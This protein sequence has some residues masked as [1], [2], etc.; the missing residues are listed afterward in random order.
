MITPPP[1][2]N[3][4]VSTARSEVR[5]SHN[6]RIVGRATDL[7]RYHAVSADNIMVCAESTVYYRHMAWIR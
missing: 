5:S 4:S 7:R 3:R 6:S 2:W 1:P